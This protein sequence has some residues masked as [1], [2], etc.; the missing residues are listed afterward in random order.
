MDK[1]LGDFTASGYLL[2]VA[3]GPFSTFFS[4]L[5]GSAVVDFLVIWGEILIGLALVFG[6]F[7][8]FA[9]YMGALMMT[10]FYL[11]VLP[12]EHG[13]ISEHIIYILVFAV[14]ASYGAGRYLGI[15]AHLEKLKVVK[16]NK[17]FKF[18][19]G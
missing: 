16:K 1:L 13:Y 11:T 18:L 6:V 2:N 3:S 10:F 15:D 8:R 17:I 12:P 7:L 9:C 5:A 4:G 19:L 14:L